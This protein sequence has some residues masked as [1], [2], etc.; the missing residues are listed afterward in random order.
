MNHSNPPRN[1]AR[2]TRSFEALFDQG[3]A[4]DIGEPVFLQ[5]PLLRRRP[6]R[7]GLLSRWLSRL[8]GTE[9]VR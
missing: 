2:P 3:R 4:P 5:A 6:R 8:L 9:P 1:G 7:P